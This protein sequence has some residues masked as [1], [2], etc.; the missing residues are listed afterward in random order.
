MSSFVTQL[1]Y[2][3]RRTLEALKSQEKH[4]FFAVVLVGSPL[5]MFFARVLVGL[6][7]LLPFFASLIFAT[8]R[9]VEILL[10]DSLLHRLYIR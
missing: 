9:V 1:F 7:F 8:T 2:R 10:M 3:V 5:H 4:L 6:L